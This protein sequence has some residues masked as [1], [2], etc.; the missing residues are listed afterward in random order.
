MIYPRLFVLCACGLMLSLSSG[1][2]GDAEELGEY[3]SIIALI[4][5]AHSFSEKQI[6]TSGY[7]SVGHRSASLFLHQADAENGLV[8]NAILLGIE[9]D[10]LKELE[11]LNNRYVRVSG[12]FFAYRPE[13]IVVARGYITVRRIILTN[14][15][16]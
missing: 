5:N 14:E 7:L 16:F 3:T 9:P 8:E 6:V 13:K 1:I 4:S 15:T 2:C 10:V 11:R 12:Q